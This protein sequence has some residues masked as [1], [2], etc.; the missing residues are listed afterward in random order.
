MGFLSTI[1]SSVGSA[2]SSAISTV[3]SSVSAGVKTF[4]ETV[5]VLGKTLGPVLGKVVTVINIIATV[6]EIAARLVNLLRPQE[7]VKEI[8][9]RA[10]QAEDEGIT[11]ESCSN[12]FNAY[13]EKLRALKLDPE[14]TAKHSD[15]DQ[16]AAGL[17]VLEKG[18][19]QCSPYLSSRSMWEIM[20]LNPQFFSK[21]RLSSYAEF[22]RDAGMPLGD[23][24]KRYFFSQ[25]TPLDRLKAMDFMEGAEKRFQPS[26]TPNDIART[27]QDAEKVITKQVNQS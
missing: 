10:L 17:L 24:V 27:L 19:E 16:Q 22:A 1:I 12:D 2:L 25:G 6:V 14:K 18:L 26:A 3:A 15:L 5:P 8:G 11:L 20:C 4:M 7:S 21:E 13:M 9:D 23:S